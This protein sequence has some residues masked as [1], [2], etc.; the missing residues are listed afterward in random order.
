ML[1]SLAVSFRKIAPDGVY[2]E[3]VA[4]R[5]DFELKYGLPFSS[6]SLL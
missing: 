3:T 2:D 1:N 5:V 4:E 6:V